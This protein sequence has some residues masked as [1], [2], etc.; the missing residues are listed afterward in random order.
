MDNRWKKKEK[1]PIGN[2]KNKKRSIDDTQLSSPAWGLAKSRITNQRRQPEH[3]QGNPRKRNNKK[4]DFDERSNG[5][6][7]I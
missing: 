3:A 4:K 6:H 2:A 1:S 7:E 5:F